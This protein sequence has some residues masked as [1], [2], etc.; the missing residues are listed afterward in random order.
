VDRLLH[1]QR[2]DSYE[3]LTQLSQ[4]LQLSLTPEAVLPAVVETVAD[5]L[6]LPYV[7]V[8]LRHGQTFEIAASIGPPDT[9]PVRLPLTY[10]QDLVGHLLCAPRPLEADFSQTDRQVLA[11]VARHTGVA[12][13]AVQL[14]AQLQR[15]RQQLV[16]AREEERRQLRH[17]LHDGIG[18]TLA[19]VVLQLSAAKTILDHDPA[20]ARQLLQRLQAEIQQAI[21]S[22][23]RLVYRLRPPALDELGLAGALREHAGHLT[24]DG[25]TPGGTAAARSPLAVEIDTPA[26]LPPLPA[27]V[28][29]AAYRIATEALAN[30]ARHAQARHCTLR[31]VVDDALELEVCDDGHGLPAAFRPGAGLT[32]MQERANELGGS[33]VIQAAPGGGTRIHAHLPIP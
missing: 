16:R 21:V 7:A 26:M 29:V 14:T 8:E 22:I 25:H 18:P 12:A 33:C 13:H 6:R 4:R 9:D 17:D 15:S 20:A 2:H 31:L 30:T 32:L 10:Q 5:T 3:V 27:A 1:G 28:E 19:G 24:A 23:R 11:D